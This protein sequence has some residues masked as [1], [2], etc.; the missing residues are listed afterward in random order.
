M[1]LPALARWHEFVA[2]NDPAIL[3]DILHPEVVFESPIVHTPQ[4]GK[5]VTARHIRGIASV[6]GRGG[7]RYV[8]T[9]TNEGGAVLEFSCELE[10]ITI[11]GVDVMKMSSDGSQ[12]VSMKVLLRPLK[13]INLVHQMMG[14][15]LGATSNTP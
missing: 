2:R 14:A 1:M 9:W 3:D 15:Q 4:R 13:A 12:I 6:F 8:N 10:G 7:F 11:N 5:V